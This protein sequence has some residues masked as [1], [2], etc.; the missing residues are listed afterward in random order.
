MKIIYTMF[1]Y[2]SHGEETEWKFI[3]KFISKLKDWNVFIFLIKWCALSIFIFLKVMPHFDFII[4]SL[5]LLKKSSSQF[6]WMKVF[7]TYSGL[8]KW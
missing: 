5:L 7:E 3:Q 1:L 4:L 6:Q 2:V 8:I